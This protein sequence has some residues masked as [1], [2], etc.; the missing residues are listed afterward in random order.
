MKPNILLYIVLLSLLSGCNGRSGLNNIKEDK[1]VLT[2]DELIG[3]QFDTTQLCASS[4]SSTS[5]AEKLVFDHSHSHSLILYFGEAMC[6]ACVQDA[7]KFVKEEL[8]FL[9]P[10]QIKIIT[11]Y[12]NVRTPAIIFKLN[13]FQLPFCN[14][15]DLPLQLA[16]LELDKPL[17]L[18][19]DQRGKII[20]LFQLRDE[21]KSR[22]RAS[23]QILI[24]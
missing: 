23:I 13:D 14:I 8:K 17:F 20:N 19:I 18:I 4:L 15:E 22:M 21:M 7:I 9:S 6:A 2:L 16:H 24:H 10:L 5:S 3:C 1:S 11:R 12:T